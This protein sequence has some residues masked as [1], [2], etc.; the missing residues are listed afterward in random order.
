MACI[1]VAHVVMAYV[2]AANIVMAYIVVVYIVMANVVI[3][4]IVVA[5][6]VMDYVVMDYVVMACTPLVYMV[7][8]CTFMAYVVM[9]HAGMADIV[10]AL[11]ACTRA[12]LSDGRQRRRWIGIAAAKKKKLLNCSVRQIKKKV[13]ACPWR[14]MDAHAMTA[15]KNTTVLFE[16]VQC[17]HLHVRHGQLCDV[18]TGAIWPQNGCLR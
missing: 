17:G 5:H 16:P 7:M 14:G 18:A 1:V 12:L 11:I 13:A 15:K 2:V 10:M 4:Y 3:A 8:G 9:A 6:V